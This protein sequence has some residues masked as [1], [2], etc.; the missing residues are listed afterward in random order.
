MANA[1]MLVKEG[2]GETANQLVRVASEE[3]EQKGVSGAVGGVLRQIPPTV[4]KPIILATEATS[5]VLGGMQSQLVPDARREAAQKWRQD[6]T[7]TN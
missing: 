7:D 3:H 1:Y 5:N 2:L 4:V 6:S